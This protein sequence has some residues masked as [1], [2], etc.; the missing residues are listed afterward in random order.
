M[1]WLL[2]LIGVNPIGKIV[3]GI[4]K[5]QKV[6]EDAKN[7]A[8]RIKADIEIKRLETK[9]ADAQEQAGVIK[10]GMDF[11]VFWIP[12]L[13]AAVPTSLWFAM[14]M[15]DS[16]FGGALPDV[17]ELPPQLKEYADTVWQNLFYTGVAGMGVQTLARAIGR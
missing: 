6:K 12:W 16:A 4:A 1:T 10:K 17:T 5:W 2:N 13:M 8:E 11:K 15:L 7:D 9:L 3:D 14:G